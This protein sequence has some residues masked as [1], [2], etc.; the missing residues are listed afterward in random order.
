MSAPENPTALFKLFLDVELSYMRI[1]PLSSSSK[2]YVDD[3]I[4]DCG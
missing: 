4:I 1:C 3:D 2:K